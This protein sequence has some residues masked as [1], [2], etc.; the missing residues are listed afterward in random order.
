[1][2]AYTFYWKSGR[3]EVLKGEDIADALINAGY[4]AIV[5]DNLSFYFPG[6]NEDFI[7]NK[8][9]RKWVFVSEN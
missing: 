6:A 7:W 4:S 8:D 9:L 5:L 1:M 3:R 2:K